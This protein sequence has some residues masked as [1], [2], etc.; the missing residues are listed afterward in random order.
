MI[1][2]AVLLAC[3][4]HA[5]AAAQSVGNA[6]PGVA[7]SV[8]APGGGL[9]PP[10]IAPGPAAPD[11]PGF[12]TPVAPGPATPYRMGLRTRPRIVTVPGLPPVVIPRGAAKRS[13]YSDRV[14]L[15]VHYGTAAGV[16]TSEIG[17]FTAYLRPV[18][19]SARAGGFST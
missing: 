16:P 15:C 5:G 9:A 1:G 10:A 11:L 7:P 14:A 8:P 6:F 3:A 18:N 13:S 17:R 19:A 2:V 4:A 12:T